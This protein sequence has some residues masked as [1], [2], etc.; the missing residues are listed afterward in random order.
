MLHRSQESTHHLTKRQ[1][2]ISVLIFCSAFKMASDDNEPPGKWNEKYNP[3]QELGL[4]TEDLFPEKVA[5]VYKAL[6]RTLHSDKVK[7]KEEKAARVTTSYNFLKHKTAPQLQEAFADIN[8]ASSNL[9]Q[10]DKLDLSNVLVDKT[11]SEKYRRL[12]ETKLKFAK[13]TKFKDNFQGYYKQVFE[14]VIPQPEKDFGYT[15][16]ICEED[17]I[18]PDHHDKLVYAPYEEYLLNGGT[19]GFWEYLEKLFAKELVYWEPPLNN[20]SGWSAEIAESYFKEWCDWFEMWKNHQEDKLGKLR[21]LSNNNDPKILKVVTILLSKTDLSVKAL[22][23]EVV[24]CMPKHD[25]ISIVFSDEL[26]LPAFL[27]V[28]SL[29]MFLFYNKKLSIYD[30]F[31]TIF[32]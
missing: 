30:I 20:S 27:H 5:K 22:C 17:F 18:Q 3:F 10:E 2:F 15:C 7:G 6:I 1:T 9:P 29:S 8:N 16:E 14:Q 21:K 11:K 28:S 4:T 19:A 24:S 31:S 12:F 26:L 13:K 25:D 23:E 32:F